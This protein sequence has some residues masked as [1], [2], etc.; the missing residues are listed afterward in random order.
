M[1]NAI[2]G[3]TA[4]AAVDCLGG[5]AYQIYASA[6]AWATLAED[7]VLHLEVAEDFAISTSDALEAVQVKRTEA[8]V[9]SNSA[10]I[11]SALEAFASITEDN[12]NRTVSLRYLTTSEIG[13]E[14]KREDRV[15]E[16]PFLVAW[17]NLRNNG[18]LSPLRK[19][20]MAIELSP[21]AKRFYAQL[22]DEDFR[23]R[24]LRRLS[25]DCG[26]AEF[27]GLKAKLEEALIELGS[28][29]QALSQD[30][31]RVR[32]AIIE[33]VLL[34]ASE[35]GGRELKRPEL[36]RIFDEQVSTS[37]PLSLVRSLLAA[38]AVG[39]GE[40][41]ASTL[42]AIRPVIE[43]LIGAPSFEG[44]APR[45]SLR[46]T[47]SQKYKKGVL[48]LHAG[49]GYGKTHLAQRIIDSEGS[50]CGVLRLRDKT[51]QQIAADLERA[52]SELLFSDYAAILIDDIDHYE[53]ALVSQPLS[54]LIGH[55]ISRN[56]SIIFTSHVKPSETLLTALNLPSDSC[57]EVERLTEDDIHHM[58]E[59][60]P[61]HVEVWQKYVHFGSSQGHPQLAHALVNGLK[62]RGWPQED[63]ANMSALLG[64]DE[65]INA[66]KEETRRRLILEMPDNLRTLAY[67]LALISS[68]FDRK[69]A[70]ALAGVPPPLKNPG[71]LLDSLTG[72]WV[73]RL[74]DDEFQLSPLLQGIGSSQLSTEEL[75][76]AHWAIASALVE[77]GTLNPRK[78]DQLILSGLA[79][80]ASGALVAFVFATMSAEASDLSLLASNC[81]SLAFFHTDR[82]I[83]P[84]EPRI[85]VQLRIIQALFLCAEGKKEQFRKAWQ[86]C[87][88][89]IDA[90]GDHEDVS[91][92]KLALGGKLLLLPQF[93]E[94]WPNFPRVV[95]DTISTAKLHGVETALA[96]SAA[97][98]SANDASDNLSVGAGLLAWQMSHLQ[99]LISLEEAVESLSKLNEEERA[100][101]VPEMDA[102][103]FD[104]EHI[105]K[106]V[107]VRL[108]ESN[109]YDS[110]T[111][112]K[113]F[114][115]LA[116]KF[117]SLGEREFALGCFS[118]AAVIQSEE[119]GNHDLAL[120][121][122]NQAE[123][124][125]GKDYLISRGK[126][127]IHFTKGEHK[128]QIEAIEPLA[129]N[130]AGR[131]S[132]EN[133]YL[134]RELAI[135]HGNLGEWDSSIECFGKA[136]EHALKSQIEALELMAI[137]LHADLAVALWKG[138]RQLDALRSISEALAR[139]NHV[140]PLKGFKQR[141]LHRLVRFAGFWMYADCKGLDQSN[142]D[143]EAQM[144]IGCCSNP[145]PHQAL[146]EHPEGST[147][148]IAYLL[149]QVEI[150]TG[151][152]AGILT[153]EIAHYS[154]DEAILPL[155]CTLAY[156]AF[157]AAVIAAKPG[158]VAHLGPKCVD[159][160]ASISA[161][162]KAQ[163]AGD[164]NGVADFSNGK[165]PRAM[166]EAWWSH[167]GDPIHCVAIFMLN[168]IASG[169]PEKI[170]E[171]MV[172]ASEEDRQLLTSEE[173]ECL[174]DGLSR[175]L[176]PTQSTFGSIGALRR[177]VE[178]GDRPVL[179]SLFI[180]TL[181]IV[182]I[183]KYLSEL[184]SFV[185]FAAKWAFDI[186]RDAIREERFRFRTPLLAENDLYLALS[187]PK[188]DLA[189][190]AG[191]VL[192][193]AP[194]MENGISAEYVERLRAIR[195]S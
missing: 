157:R 61:E 167:R 42:G 112:S 178:G 144:V 126:A 64:S 162:R 77:G 141:A 121:I 41:N 13:R 89:E 38:K 165:P 18:D 9:T 40:S 158:K 92:L 173:G 142:P 136:E 163:E 116:E 100:A 54:L 191:I 71:E 12:P 67:R 70:K 94:V 152:D 140:D 169:Q 11:I 111:C 74:G 7:E 21:A 156:E 55:C 183:A 60:A 87:E 114:L 170:D 151:I 110:E 15:G 88:R 63:L 95:V 30:S 45:K 137:G 168:A 85:S 93:A 6:L 4:R 161:E 46:A 1:D 108:K 32:S 145:N 81:V 3:D 34:T 160:L 26:E 122:L 164:I 50:D 97:E 51:T 185:E 73:E 179:P 79:G 59:G 31:L 187:Y 66:T 16:E 153:G 128:Q 125:L 8:S 58:V 86:A 65:S 10:G 90:L 171:Y 29:R 190:L 96:V 39:A 48:W 24:V 188:R 33:R 129:S 28:R 150:E 57:V 113:D 47:L 177:S 19:R 139:V 20:L 147:R 69:V 101:V 14:K 143:I 104:P 17:A 194:Y 120:G 172:A 22:S 154:D 62:R 76:E 181:R 105:A 106:S 83:Y 68:S 82:L 102:I 103:V 5:Y 186:W 192:A 174:R 149:A 119:L 117:H 78:L 35:K 115:R 84:E 135:A 37:V 118:T 25:F 130:S 195:E 52:R 146:D 80:R 56:Q 189:G 109:V 127:G 131:G 159:A 182:D 175:A 72:P 184:G 98:E 123:D 132:I 36:F 193:V 49:T 124:V 166:G 134:F 53:T 133:A 107:W 75:Q 23:P 155:E 176:D 2:K 27:V 148:M 180:A 44:E 138:G 43:N 99:S 91:V